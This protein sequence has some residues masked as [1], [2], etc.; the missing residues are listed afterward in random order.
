[1]A[2]CHFHQYLIGTFV[3]VLPRLKASFCER[4][5]G[6]GVSS[7]QEV[8]DVSAAALLHRDSFNAASEAVLPLAPLPLSSL[9][10]FLSVCLSFLQLSNC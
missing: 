9:C 6:A 1:M 10:S 4:L 8:P 3:S 2:L 5:L 7:L